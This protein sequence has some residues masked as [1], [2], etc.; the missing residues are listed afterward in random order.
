MLIIGVNMNGIKKIGFN[1][2]GVLNKIGLLILKNVGIIEVCLMVWL[3]F[4]L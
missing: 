4:D 1:M 3:C 2:I